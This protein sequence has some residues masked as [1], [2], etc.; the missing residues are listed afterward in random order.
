MADLPRKYFDDEAFQDKLTC[1]LLRDVKALQEC[2]SVLRPDDFKPL[3]GMRNGRARWIVAERALEYYNKYHMPIGSLITADVIEYATGIGMG[4]QQRQEL[5]KYLAYL[6]KLKPTAPDAVVSKVLHYK[7]ERMRAAAI[8]ELVD[9]Q[10][11]GQLTEA[12]WREIS[13]RALLNGKGQVKP[14]S[15]LETLAARMERRRQHADHLIV[16][17]TLIDPLDR[18]VQ[19]IGPQQTGL[20][21]APWKR[22]KSLMLQWLAR[23]LIV[24]R[25]N[26]LYFTLEDAQRIVEDRFDAMITEIDLKRLSEYPIAVAQRFER[27][28]TTVAARLKIYDGTAGGVT[29]SRI[30][31]VYL[32]ERDSGFLA[33]AVIVDYD[34]KIIPA[35][36]LSERRFEY[37]ALYTAQQQ[38][39]SRYNLIYWTAAQTQRGTRDLKILS[40]DKV[41]E[42]INKMR[43][44]TCALTLGKGDWGKDS[45]YIWVA[46]HKNDQMEVGCHIVSNLR[47][48]LIYDCEATEASARQH[49]TRR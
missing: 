16:P 8:Q 7:G 45:I 42:D 20:I 33:D 40:G 17:Y 26:V 49:E 43:N 48:S 24:Q 31:E 44:V 13:V 41:A 9:L 29:L 15:Y 1:V 18:M 14:I 32:A 23:A 25:R 6:A 22:G 46:A 36:K 11:I 30:E 39:A 34:A 28:R 35:Q 12:K 4:E 27:F 47:R 19:T 38:F 3:P 2:A 5:Q 37:D 21:V 10:S